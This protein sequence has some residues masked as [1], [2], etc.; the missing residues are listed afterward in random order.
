MKLKD[1]IQTL[2]EKFDPITLNEMDSVK[3]MDRTDVKYIFSINKLPNILGKAVKDYR[4]LKIK[5]ERVH[6][7]NNQYFDTDD[8]E[9]YSKHHSG[10]LNRYKIRYRNYDASNVAFLEIKFKT[11]KKRTI[12]KRIRNISTSEINKESSSFIERNSPYKSSELKPVLINEF[13]R[14]TLVH[15]SEKERITLDF[16]ISYIN[17]FS[18]TNRTYYLPKLVIGEIKRTGFSNSS[19]FIAIL[20]SEG[21]RQS[22][23]SKYCIGTALLNDNLKHNRFKPKLIYIKSIHK[24]HN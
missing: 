3:L 18:D 1:K 14:I 13:Q 2:I 23:I 20:K 9:M 17:S 15:K 21:I 24:S 11:N 4:I 5:N 22:S 19:D 10:K 16:N 12:K 8:Y 7:Y 6:I